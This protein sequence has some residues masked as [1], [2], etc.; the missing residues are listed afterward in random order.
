MSVKEIDLPQT[1]SDE[2]IV[3]ADAGYWY[4]DANSQAF[5]VSF[6]FHILLVLALAIT[7]LVSSTRSENVALS[8]IAH[9]FEEEFVVTEEM[10][11][12]ENLPSEVGANSESD[13]STALSMAPVIA[14]ISEMPAPAP[15]LPVLNATYDLNNQIKQ[16][17]GL[18]KS[19]NVVRG[20]TGV[21]T[22]GTAGAVDRIT[23]EILRAMEQRPTLVVWLFDQSGSLQQRRLEI[24]NRFDRIYSELGIARQQ[25]ESTDEKTANDDYLLTAVISFGS[26]VNLLTKKPTSDLDEIRA[27]ID[28]VTLDQ[29]GIERVF[30]AIYLALDKFKAYRSASTGHGPERN[31]LFIAVSDERGDDI[32]GMD[33]TIDLCRKSAIPVYVVGVPAPFGREFTYVKYVDPD[34]KFDQTPQ[35]AQVDQGPESLFPERVKIGYKDNYYDEPVLD[36]GF[37]PY[38]LSRL[39]YE[40]GGIYFTVHP[41]RQFGRR[42][43]R[44]EI[45]P[46]ASELAYFFNPEVMTRY[47]PDYVSVD[48]YSKKVKESPLRQALVAASRLT[49]AE[50][51]NQPV[52]RFVKRD[53]ASLVNSLTTAQQQAARLAPQLEGLASI[54]QNGVAYRD[55]EI[56]PRWLAGFDLAMGVVLAHKVRAEGY[57]AMLAKA[58]R[59]IPFQLPRNNTWI[60]TPDQEISVGSKLEKE[61][62]IARDLLKKV[63]EQH[64]GTPWGML[65]SRELKIPLGWTWVEDFTDLAPN[66]PGARGN[67]GNNVPRPAQD[68]KAKMLGPQAPKRPIPKL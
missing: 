44:G 13:I 60:L 35:W 42:V 53:E 64:T 36:S 68:E 66:R 40:T 21:G 5:L 48:D 41:N 37:G 32:E 28:A 4:V 7:P 34:P 31:V 56:S 50:T 27:A 47:R 29:T 1:A 59:G 67:N 55:K 9:E 18:T 33:K 22:T 39:C 58:K 51:L 46:F 16:P 49:A 38:A 6:V 52:T 3:V 45:D 23:S 54:L 11:P 20:M 2:D 24:R 65:A 57:N 61:G 25:K 62:E 14:E 15:E 26:R 8:A 12:A 30:S 10:A 63:A 17:V 43:N 19:E